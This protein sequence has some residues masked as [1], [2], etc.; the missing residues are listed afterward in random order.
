MSTLPAAGVPAY[1]RPGNSV[2]PGSVSNKKALVAAQTMTGAV[3]GLGLLGYILDRNL[4]TEPALLVAG[5]LL[6]LVVGFYELWR[7]MFPPEDR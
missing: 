1:P 2:G 4:E 3:I 5:L 7:A 6:G